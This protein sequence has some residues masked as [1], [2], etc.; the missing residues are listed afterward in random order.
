[1]VTT[2][3][4]AGRL[5]IPAQIRKEAAL[6]PGTPLEVRVRDGVIEIEPQALEVTLA[7]R[8]RLVVATPVKKIGT[9]READV[10]RT[11]RD[12]ARRRGRR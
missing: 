7:R 9:L 11:R 3:D 5:V 2:I 4:S 1:M 6:E 10:E 8:G 12:L